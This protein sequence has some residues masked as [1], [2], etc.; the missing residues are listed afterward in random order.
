MQKIYSDQARLLISVL[1]HVAKETCF[2]LK[3]GT[4]IN[5]FVR[6]MPRLSV[7][8]DLSYLPV[9]DRDTSLKTID[10]ALKSI[11][12]RIQKAIPGSV[13][14]KNLLTGTKYYNR[15]LISRDGVTI[16]VEVTPVL[17]GS[18]H[19]SQEKEISA[20]AEKEFGYVRMQL[21][22]FEDLY[23]GKLCA[24]LDR[25]HPRDLYDI[26]YLLKNEGITEIIKNTFLVYLISHNRPMAEL[27]HPRPQDI[28]TLYES[29]FKGMTYEYVSLE[30]LY[31]TRKKIVELIH[32]GL[33]DND[34][35]FLFSLK[36]GDP[37]WELFAYPEA[38]SLPAVR[39]K[40][41]NLSKMTEN[42]KKEAVHKLKEAL[43]KKY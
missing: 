23:G 17:R 14:N 21:L 10:T 8:I 33:S 42:K 34:R 31:K 41:H 43:S 3:G 22:S 39:W 28:S 32:E 11:E 27:L 25:Q 18:V 16:K 13:I 29:E 35:M 40:L 4:A 24:A 26:H 30:E 36:N 6:N 2:A 37:K 9:E 1:P 15:L 19:P 5:L 12:S 7:D 20:K 38:A